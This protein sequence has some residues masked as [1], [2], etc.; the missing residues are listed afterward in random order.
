MIIKGTN[1]LNKATV[2]TVKILYSVSTKKDNGNGQNI[3]FLLTPCAYCYCHALP[4]IILFYICFIKILL[5][6]K[7][8]YNMQMKFKGF[9]VQLF[10]Y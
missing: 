10:Q 1:K 5:S 6:T 3:L 9:F 4:C 7:G 8:N 2:L